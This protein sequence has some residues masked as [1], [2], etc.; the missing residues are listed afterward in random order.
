MDQNKLFADSHQSTEREKMAPLSQ[1]F[2]HL[3]DNLKVLDAATGCKKIS[4]C[5]D[6]NRIS[7]NEKS[8]MGIKFFPIFKYFFK[9]KCCLGDSREG[10]GLYSQTPYLSTYVAVA[11]AQSSGRGNRTGGQQGG[12]QEG[13]PQN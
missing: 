5:K 2:H 7:L 12:N 13:G 4:W 9:Q 1:S 8:F 6:S 11:L 10:G 3:K